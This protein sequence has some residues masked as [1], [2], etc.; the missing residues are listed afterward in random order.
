MSELFLRELTIY[1][2]R[3]YFLADRH[4]VW[5]ICQSK[6]LVFVE[7]QFKIA[8]VLLY[9]LMAPISCS[10]TLTN[11]TKMCQH[12][13]IVGWNW[14]LCTRACAPFLGRISS[15]EGAVRRLVPLQMLIVRHSLLFLC[16]FVICVHSTDCIVPAHFLE[17][18]PVSVA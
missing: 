8:S 11:V 16:G 17:Q 7:L 4:I 18:S 15:A 1:A 6:C 10:F 12:F 14:T 13:S 3:I 9:L 5:V 2:V